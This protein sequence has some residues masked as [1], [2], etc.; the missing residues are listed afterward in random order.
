MSSFSRK[1]EVCRTGMI[2]LNT[3]LLHGIVHSSCFPSICVVIFI[4]DSYFPFSTSIRVSGRD[5]LLFVVGLHLFWLTFPMMV[6]IYLPLRLIL[7]GN[8]YIFWHSS[9]VTENTYR[10]RV[11]L[12]CSVSRRCLVVECSCYY[13]IFPSVS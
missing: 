11:L 5:I 9:R 12:N 2:Y 3:I 1:F 4:L 8:S 7:N 13:S 10:F 6:I